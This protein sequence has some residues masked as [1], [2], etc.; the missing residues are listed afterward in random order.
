MRASKTGW[1][2]RIP[3]TR[4]VRR[5]LDLLGPGD[6]ADTIFAFP[7]STNFRAC[8]DQLTKLCLTARVPVVTLKQLRC[9]S[10][11]LWSS[12][13]AEAGKIIHGCGLGVMRHY[14]DPLA[15]LEAAAPLVRLPDVFL[16]DEERASE[17]KHRQ[18]L[19]DLYARAGRHQKRLILGV[20]RSVAR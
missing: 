18:E 20:A 17:T 7:R 13:N 1:V 6:R 10:I 19:L 15:V 4:T 16:T 14:L 9:L 3:L 2:H 12:T 11:T 8:Y 5:H